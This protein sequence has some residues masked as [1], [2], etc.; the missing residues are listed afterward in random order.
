MGVAEVKQCTADRLWR[1]KWFGQPLFPN[2]VFVPGSCAKFLTQRSRSIEK[3][4]I[5]IPTLARVTCPERALHGWG[6]IQQGS[7]RMR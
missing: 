2:P 5:K 3:A 6:S 7:K 1:L 4:S